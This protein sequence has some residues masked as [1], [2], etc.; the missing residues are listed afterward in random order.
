MA[1]T[2]SPELETHLSNLARRLGIDGPDAPEQALKMAVAE[3]EA[4]ATPSR[5]KLSPAEV[6][7][8]MAPIVAAARR[9]R[10]EHP[11]DDDNPPS[12][13]WQEELYDEQGLPK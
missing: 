13:T 1:M 10:E 12:K 3:L 9:W 6:A 7:A 8:E 2:L 4:K 11:F 5:R